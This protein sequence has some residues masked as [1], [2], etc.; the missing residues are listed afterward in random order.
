[1]ACLPDRSLRGAFTI[2]E[3]VV[4][5]A[6]LGILAALI[7]PNYQSIIHK[8]QEAVCTS[9]M[10]SI[11]VALA[12]Y[13]QDHQDVWPQGPYPRDNQAWEAFWLATLRPYDINENT[14]QC[15]T[16]KRALASSEGEHHGS[17]NGSAPMGTAR[18]LLSPTA[19]S[20]AWIKCWPSGVFA[21]SSPPADRGIYSY[22]TGANK[23]D[24]QTCTKP[25]LMLFASACDFVLL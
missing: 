5:L 25:N 4:V 19:R 14:W 6:I 10:R 2:L 17:L 11:H 20:K 18:Y 12:N 23:L 21:D 16:L 15:P 22:P 3:L 7:L 24:P 8:S 13:L 9:H 1:M